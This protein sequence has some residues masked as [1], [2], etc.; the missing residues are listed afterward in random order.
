MGR[1]KCVYMYVCVF[2][3]KYDMLDLWLG[4]YTLVCILMLCIYREPDVF[5][6]LGA[7]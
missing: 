1:M 7:A 4:T 3:E 2:Y 5:R 6:D